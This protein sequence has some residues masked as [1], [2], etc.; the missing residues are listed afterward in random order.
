MP[1]TD[2]QFAAT[3]DDYLDFLISAEY[4]QEFGFAA[5]YCVQA[6]DSS[7]SC[8]YI[9][10]EAFPNLSVHTAAYSSI[11]KLYGLIDNIPTDQRR[12]IELQQ[13]TYLNLTGNNVLI[14]L[15]GTGIHYTSD[16]FKTSDGRTRIAA[17][18]DQTIQDGNAP[19]GIFFGTEY[20]EDQINQALASDSPLTV[21]PSTDTHGNGTY[22]ASAAAA[23]DSVTTDFRGVAPQASL[24]VVKL[25]EAKPYLKSFYAVPSDTTAYQENDILLAIKYLTTLA[26]QRALPLVICLGIG[27]SLGPHDGSGFLPAYIN[28]ISIGSTC[29]VTAVGDEADTQ[30]HY[31]N[32]F[33]PEDDYIDVEVR[34]NNNPTGFF[35]EL[36]GFSP[37]IFSVSVISPGGEI[38]PRVPYR[39]N[40]GTDYRFTFEETD[41]T[42][43]YQ[44]ADERNSNP[45]IT[46]KMTSPANGIWTFRIFCNSLTS[47]QFHMWLP[48]DAFIQGE[49]YFLTSNP[50][51]TLTDPATASTSLSIAAY[52][53]ER[54]SI[55]L[56]S[57]RGYSLSGRIKPILAAPGV[58]VPGINLRDSI[59]VRNG[60]SAS[61]A[62]TAGACALIL[63]WSISLE[64]APNL[65]AARLATQLIRGADRSPNRTYPNR[66][67]GYGTLNLE[68]TF[69]SFLPQ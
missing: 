14:G 40:T 56:E 21:V 68:N 3:S 63:Q 17:I 37:D 60:T 30:H 20:T 24:A 65:G 13:Q 51:S 66:S 7:V 62:L 48:I 46:M 5:N 36:W 8:V 32:A 10:G 11:P 6:I 28:D 33:T 42:I 1:D 61:A 35:M 69:Q 4:V 52:D 25:K 53:S 18:W 15:V 44:I 50:E 47:G 43:R 34:V 16:Y 38:L 9:P 31:S 64:N 58:A 41:F 29:V 57:G 26:R 49:T 67:W 23:S 27:T 22:L 55:L 2:C 59:T 19:E 45:L 54:N 39:V 12:T